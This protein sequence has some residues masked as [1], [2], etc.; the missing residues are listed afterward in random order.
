M[1]TSIFCDHRIITFR[2]E[3]YFGTT[4]IGEYRAKGRSCCHSCMDA[5]VLYAGAMGEAES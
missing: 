2:E 3:D 4:S 5:E 1:R